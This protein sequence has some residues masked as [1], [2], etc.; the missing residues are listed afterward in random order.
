[1]QIS[2]LGISLGLVTLGILAW[3]A[4]G[5][6]G[7]RLPRMLRSGARV[8]PVAPAVD[9]PYDSMERY[10]SRQRALFARWAELEEFRKKGVG[11][12]VHWQGRVGY[13]VSYTDGT[14]GMHLWCTDEREMMGVRLSPAFK[15]RAFALP[16]GK[17]VGVTGTLTGSP[18]SI[19][20]AGESLQALP[21]LP[22]KATRH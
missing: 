21:D 3:I 22:S 7:Q 2:I 11:V 16:K 19:S 4:A 10:F 17:L 14:V 12:H 20:I 13:V 6:A 8:A 9:A 1:M 5:W 18:A 15:E